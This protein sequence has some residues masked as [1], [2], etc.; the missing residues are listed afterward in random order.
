MAVAIDRLLALDRLNQVLAQGVA[1]KQEKNGD[2]GDFE[3]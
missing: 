2:V 1:K 3:G